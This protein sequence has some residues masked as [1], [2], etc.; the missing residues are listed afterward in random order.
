MFIGVFLGIGYV[1]ASAWL[2]RLY[3]RLF[4]GPLY[5]ATQKFGS[6]TQVFVTDYYVLLVQI[7]L[8]TSPFLSESETNQRYIAIPFVIVLVVLLWFM[9]L[10]VLSKARVRKLWPR[11]V[12]QFLFPI[13]VIA[14]LAF[15]FYTLPGA[16]M[17]IFMPVV[18][19]LAILF[20]ILNVLFN[21]ASTWI[22][23]HADSPPPEPSHPQQN[24]I[25]DASTPSA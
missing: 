8:F 9:G 12:G 3:L 21:K 25:F 15:G 11:L 19:V 7:A 24:P 10:R 13:E 4:W 1:A 18:G 22:L 14:A 6:R 2:T 17:I 23:S 5:E 16:L 20:L